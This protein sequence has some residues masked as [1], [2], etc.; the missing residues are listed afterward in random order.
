[1]S[2]SDVFGTDLALLHPPSVYD[3]RPSVIMHGP[4]ADAVPSTNEFEM[5]PVGLTSIA[6]YLSANHYNVRISNLAYLMLA[7]PDFD[8]E[9]HVARMRP[10]VP[11]SSTPACARWSRTGNGRSTRPRCCSTP[12]AARSNAR[13]DPRLL[14]GADLHGAALEST[15]AS[16]LA[17]GCRKLDLFFM[18]GIPGQRPQ[19][20]LATVDYCDHLV[21]RFGARHSAGLDPPARRGGQ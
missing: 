17:H 19:D 11:S 18:V 10:K 2:V 20:A 9:A 8:V 1:M 4:I 16:V 13:G 21:A 15:V 3:F 12:A 7:E 6:S 14:G 5:Y